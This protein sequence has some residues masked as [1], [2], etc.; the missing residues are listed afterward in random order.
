MPSRSF[1]NSTALKE[2][3]PADISGSLAL[4]SLPRMAAT[5]SWTCARTAASEAPGAEAL[6]GRETIFLVDLPFFFL[7]GFST[8]LKWAK[9]E[10]MAGT[11]LVLYWLV[12]NLSHENGMQV[13]TLAWF[14][15]W[16]KLA[17]AS[18]PVTGSTSPSPVLSTLAFVDA[19]LP[20]MPLPAQAPHWMLTDDRPCAVDMVA[21]K[22][23]A[24]FA[25]L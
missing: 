21:N 3:S 4:T 10:N 11:S 23:R 16:I 17:M 14:H 9:L 25:A 8:F 6:F 1:L 18:R 2:S 13:T 15:P 24:L 22:S 5:A 12:M 7:E 20:A 19:S